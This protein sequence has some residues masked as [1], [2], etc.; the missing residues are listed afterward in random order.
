MR[1]KVHSTIYL[2]GLLTMAFFMPLSIFVTNAAML[3][4]ATNWLVE[5]N[6]AEKWKRIKE[7]FGILIFCAL[8][9][10][11]LIWL[12][13]TSDFTYAMNDLRIKLPLLALP[14]FFG[15]SEPLSTKK[16]NIILITFV[17]GVF[18]ASLMGVVAKIFAENSD[19]R[20]LSLFISNIRMSLMLCLSFFI[21]AYFIVKK[22]FFTK[23][24]RWI[25]ICVAI[26][27]LIFMSI[28]QSITGSAC[29]F[30]ALTTIL[31]VVAIKTRN[32]I[33]RAV[34]ITLAAII[35]I[36]ITA[37]I[38]Y[39]VHD[40]Y[41]PTCDNVQ[42]KTTAAGNPYDEIVSDGTI[43]NGNLVWLN[44][45]KAELTEAWA[46]R[47]TIHID[48]LDNK[49]QFIYPTLVRYM[50]SLGLTKDAEGISKM[51]DTDIKNVENGETNYRF[52]NR[53]GLACRI[54]VIIWEIDVYRK[55]GDC[56]GHSAVQRIEF[57]KYGGKLAALNLL[58]GTGTGDVNEE[59]Q[60]LYEE[61]NS[62]LLPEFRHRAHNQF[63]TFMISFGIIGFIICLLAWFVP[64]FLKWDTN[65]FLFGIFFLI[66][67]ISMFSDDTLETTTGTVFVAF[68]F[69]L[70]KWTTDRK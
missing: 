22:T 55:T 28:I 43:E 13:N 67:T 19:F 70:L 30:I 39:S 40:F 25:A 68:F 34:C 21:L 2:I 9:I 17:A 47:S 50:T 63:L 23:A 24:T 62:N 49:G 3:M 46:K 14:I 56:N 32:K 59:F 37:F 38:A 4:I 53:S 29:L 64:A 66:A 27:L 65:K 5:C 26:W 42:L 48:S 7:N 10:T 16:L 61:E 69:S 15:T 33:H 51:S 44:I 58:T 35:P 41:T 57:L 20:S 31:I 11:H 8:Y 54:Y 6:F 18:T 36:T 45:S 60:K 1:K 12:A 52:A